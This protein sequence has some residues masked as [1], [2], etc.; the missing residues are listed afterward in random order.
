MSLFGHLSLQPSISSAR[1]LCSGPW[2][3]S[4]FFFFFLIEMEKGYKRGSFP[5][6]IQNEER[7]GDPKNKNGVGSST[8]YP[9]Q[10]KIVLK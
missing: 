7:M 5:F 9:K 2:T 8:T 4:S 6:L 3:L 1:H 10:T